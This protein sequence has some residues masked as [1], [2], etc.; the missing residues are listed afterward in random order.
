MRVVDLNSALA[1]FETHYVRST[2]TKI[3]IKEKQD[4]MNGQNLDKKTAEI[5]K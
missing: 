3:E 1:S 4:K 2:Y 5:N